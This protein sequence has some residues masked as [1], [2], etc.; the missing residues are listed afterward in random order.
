M[1]TKKIWWNPFVIIG[2]AFIIWMYFFDDNS[3]RIHRELNDEIQRL[4]TS[5]QYYETEIAKDKKVIELYQNDD[6]LE[7][8]AREK[9]GL[10]KENEDVYI[11]REE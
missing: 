4:E 5:I 6:S 2:I 1:N 8:F 10:K 3:L 11:I 9:Y 7:K